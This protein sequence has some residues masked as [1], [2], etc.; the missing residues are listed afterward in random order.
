MAEADSPSTSG[1]TSSAREKQNRQIQ[2]E[3][4][5]YKTACGSV[6]DFK[7][8]FDPY[9]DVYNGAEGSILLMPRSNLPQNP[10]PLVLIQ[11][12]IH[13]VDLLIEKLAN[14]NCLSECSVLVSLREIKIE[15]QGEK[16]V[17]ARSEQDYFRWREQ[18]ELRQETRRRAQEA[19]RARLDETYRREERR[20]QE[21]ARRGQEAR[22]ARLDE[23]HRR[24]EERRRRHGEY[25]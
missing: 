22:R 17:A 6:K 8:T 14:K 19:R 7:E 11:E 1:K 13:R 24:E 25:R 3:Y 18:E 12:Y 9:K 2:K 15:L 20:R 4:A 23:T 10:S 21:E 5:W 16:E